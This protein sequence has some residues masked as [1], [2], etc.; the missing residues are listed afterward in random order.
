MARA[1]RIVFETLELM[2][3]VVRPGLS[4]ED[5]DR[6]V[7][8]DIVSIDLHFPR[9]LIAGRALSDAVLCFT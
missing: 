1:G 9:R 3:K 8:L 7:R 6:D 4:T 5:L 2:R